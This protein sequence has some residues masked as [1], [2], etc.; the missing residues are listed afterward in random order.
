MKTHTLIV[1]SL[2]LAISCSAIAVEGGNPKKGKHLYKKHCKACHSQSAQ[3]GELTPMSKTM[4]Q[5]DRFFQRN[6]HKAKPEV[7]QGLADKA[8][9]DI[10]QFLYNHAADSDQPATCG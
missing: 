5:W 9:L 4:A 10:Q 6:K 3:G 1:S 8:L 7:F 2:A